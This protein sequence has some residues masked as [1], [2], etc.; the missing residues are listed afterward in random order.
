MIAI[1]NY[2]VG[3]IKSVMSALRRLEI[4]A[5]LTADI[6]EIEASDGVILPGV[7]AFSAAMKELKEKKLVAPVIDLANSGKPIFGVCVGHQLLFTES[8]EHGM[9]KGLGLIPGRVVRFR[10]APGI[11]HMGWNQVKYRKPSVL[12]EGIRDGSFF[13]FAHS[14]YTVPA[15]DS[16]IIADTE[17]GSQFVSC[18]REGNVF[19]AQFHPEKSGK[20]GLKLLLNFSKYCANCNKQAR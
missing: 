17:H 20:Q 14:F 2:G 12:F 5:I 9:Y 1:I 10:S 3:N 19:G 16:V 8:E 18:V 11:P 13:Y 7:G 4:E 6:S 15:D